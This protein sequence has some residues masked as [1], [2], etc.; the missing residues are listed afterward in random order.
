VKYF[1]P[2]EAEQQKPQFA[3]SRSPERPRSA[4]W[5][6]GTAGAKMVLSVYGMTYPAIDSALHRVEQLCKEAEK[7]QVVRHADVSKLSPSQVTDRNTV[8]GTD[9]V[10]HQNS[11]IGN[12]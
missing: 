3:G 8:A 5:S 7:T 6:R 1:N 11:R 12:P 10:V 4:P 2:S 9:F